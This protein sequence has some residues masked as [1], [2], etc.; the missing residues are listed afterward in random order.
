VLEELCCNEDLTQFS[1]KHLCIF[2]L[3]LINNKV[4]KKKQTRKLLL[5]YQIN[6]FAKNKSETQRNFPNYRLKKEIQKTNPFGI[7]KIQ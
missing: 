6:L 5:D 4:R 2:F 1:L 3:G 7:W